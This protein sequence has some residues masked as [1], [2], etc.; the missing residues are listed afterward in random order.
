[1]RSVLLTAVA[2][3]ALAGCV[4]L[5]L[6]PSEFACGTGGPCAEDATGDAGAKDAFGR[7]DASDG[8]VAADA[9]S[10]VDSGADDAGNACA[11]GPSGSWRLLAVT[12]AIPRS[13]HSAVVDTMRNRALVFG[14]AGADSRLMA[15]SAGTLAFEPVVLTSTSPPPRR[16]HAAA[17]NDEEDG[18]V[19]IFGGLD[20]SSSELDDA[21]RLSFVNSEWIF[22]GN[23]QSP[24]HGAAAAVLQSV[25]DYIAILGGCDAGG[26][27]AA[28]QSFDVIINSVGPLTSN[29]PKPTPRCDQTATFV[30]NLGTL[31]FG[32]RNTQ[33]LD[34]LWSLR[35][36]T[37]S[38][39]FTRN[40]TR[41]ASGPARFGHTAVFDAAHNR[42]LVFGGID[43]SGAR[44]Q[45][46]QAYSI[47]NGC[48][49]RLSP[50]GGG[51]SA[52]AQHA[53]FMLNGMMYVYG[54]DDGST[55]D[56]VWELSF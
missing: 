42:L 19:M 53:A 34:D 16:E 12:G 20:P 47:D 55:R 5:P 33:A 50:S 44:L 51:P 45:D 13:G 3:C 43:A 41:L 2:G 49:A 11:A 8:D 39:P 1:M 54:G 46:T 38:L 36:D 32:G 9:G 29:A 40:W 24:R 30:P 37:S 4:D 23:L 21:W 17:Y 6:L 56:D 52:R 31:V 7:A 26:P 10:D 48:W 22:E 28:D 25:V 35:E 27:V 18:E 14:G 15:F